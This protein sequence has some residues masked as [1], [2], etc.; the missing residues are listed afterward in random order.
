MLNAW[1][2]SSWKY[3]ELSG[4]Y[5][6][7][8][9]MGNGCTFGLESLIF[10]AAARAVGSRD[11]CVYG[12]D[13]IIETELYEPLVTLLSALG[14]TTNSEKSFNQGPFRESC[15]VDAY[16]GTDITPFYVRTWNPKSGPEFSHNI[17]GLISI[18][19]PGGAL[20]NFLLRLLKKTPK[21]VY[22]PYNS[23][24]TTGVFLPASSAYS[25]RLIRTRDSIPRFLG[26]SS[27]S[28][29]EVIADSV[30]LALWF[31]QK[32]HHRTGK[33]VVESSRIPLLTHKYVKK[34]L[35]WQVPVTGTPSHLYWWADQIIALRP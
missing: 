10:A 11:F 21:V 34:W 16:L 22:V 17:N 33:S 3:D 35:N 5:H 28:K 2:S 6:K 26:Y 20:S 27:K 7:F 24:T 30:S 29:H 23:D 4:H 9:S 31:L 12:D 15:G 32:G 14:F 25:K 1:R 18:S 19:L 13:I 8:S